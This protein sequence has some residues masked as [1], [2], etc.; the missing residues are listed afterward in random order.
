MKT[1]ITWIASLLLLFSFGVS[2]QEVE[3]K[4]VSPEKVVFN[5]HWFMQLQAGAAHTVGETKFGDLI[6]P[7]AAVNFGY[8]FSPVFGLR[9]GASG[10]QAK[11]S[12]VAPRIDYKFNYIQGNVDAMLSLTNLFCGFNPTRTLDFYGFLGVAGN[13]R[14]HNNEAIA[15]Q[16]QGADF[17]YLWTGHKWSFAG[18]GGLGVN[19]RLSNI[20]GINVEANANG[21]SDHW[22]SKKGDNI[23]WQFNLLAGLTI[24]FG[25]NH[26]VIPAVYEEIPLPEPEPEPAPAPKPEPKPEPAP[27][28]KAEPMT[29]NI[30]FIINSSKIRKSEQEKVD[31]LVE[32]LKQYP[33]AR[34]T[35]TGYADKGTGTSA[36]NMQISKRRAQAVRTALVNAGIDESRITEKAEGDAVQPFAVNKENRVVIAVARD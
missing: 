35:V 18:R 14:F 29:Q 4:Q 2:A 13:N 10:W 3:R 25:K 30:F 33:D 5:P 17:E 9:F 7:A 31:M 21:Y 36:Y 34:V 11:G 32:Y 27:V 24:R 22:N 28:V 19:I 6:S 1:S 8:Q 16:A 23:D 26:K 15:A 12:W 20:V